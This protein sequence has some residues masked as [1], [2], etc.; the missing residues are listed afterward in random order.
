MYTFMVADAASQVC[1]LSKPLVLVGVCDAG[2][3]GGLGSKVM[4]G[5]QYFARNC[6]GHF[7]LL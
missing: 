3:F 7:V 4:P 6:F 2:V 5:V 1:V